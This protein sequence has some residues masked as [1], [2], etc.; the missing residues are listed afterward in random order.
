MCA[1]F[2]L[3]T[4]VQASTGSVVKLLWHIKFMDLNFELFGSVIY[5]FS[6]FFLFSLLNVELCLQIQNK[7]PFFHIRVQKRSSKKTYKHFISFILLFHFGVCDEYNIWK[8][9]NNRIIQFGKCFSFTSQRQKYIFKCQMNNDRR[10]TRGM[11][12]PI[13]KEN[14]Y[15]NNW[16]ERKKTS[17]W[18]QHIMP[19]WLEE[20]KRCQAMK[21][22]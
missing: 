14:G 8:Y 20:N 6:F 17:K 13:Q 21:K 4:N 16:T 1:F 22:K 2:F 10:G 18:N 3:S 19:K 9:G 5:I 11:K 7:S 15:D 12:D